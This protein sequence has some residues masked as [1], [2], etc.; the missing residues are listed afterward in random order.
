MNV[1][2]HKVTTDPLT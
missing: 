1:D 2:Q